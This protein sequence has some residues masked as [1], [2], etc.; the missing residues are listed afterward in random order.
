M[1]LSLNPEKAVI[2]KPPYL[3]SQLIPS[4]KL[5][6]LG[7]EDDTDRRLLMLQICAAVQNGRALFDGAFPVVQGETVFF[8]SGPGER[9]RALEIARM[10]G[11]GL[12]ILTARPGMKELKEYLLSHSGCRLL[13]IEDTV[14]Q[15]PIFSRWVERYVGDAGGAKFV[16][17]QKA[18][19]SLPGLQELR[20]ELA[21]EFMSG[22]LQIT[23]ERGITIIMGHEL[24]T[25]GHLYDLGTFHGMDNLLT[26]RQHGSDGNYRLKIE[27][28]GLHLASGEWILERDDTR[29]R[30]QLD[31]RSARRVRQAA[32][33]EAAPLP[34]T[35]VEGVLIE[36]L[37]EH[38]PLKHSEIE[39]LKL[40]NPNKQ[41][42]ALSK[43]TISDRL[44]ALMKENKQCVVVRDED[45]RWAI[46]PDK[47][48]I[49]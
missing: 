40:P 49:V 26:L 48:G 39:A 5:I 12:E 4:N 7:T 14:A 41:G 43:G 45:G 6:V 46:N 10:W 28:R 15:R 37:K 34:F 23:S 18:N 17:N 3:V 36:A 22:L 47:E 35:L 29:D 25:S 42:S 30:F 27:R 2:D 31:Q 11:E 9:D 38:G 24:N 20:R 19:M 8:A 16:Q 33:A 1:G 32:I 44:K 21:K 13:C